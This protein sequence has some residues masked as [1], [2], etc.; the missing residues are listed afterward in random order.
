MLLKRRFLEG[1][2]DGS[3]SLVFRRWRKPTVKVGG[4]LKTA[5]GVLAIDDIIVVD[6]A[7]ITDADA[8]R[9]GY[10]SAAEL[11]VELA[12]RTG[13][14]IY[15]IRVRF[16][17]A[18]P[19]IALRAD[20]C[21]DDGAVHVLARLQRLDRASPWTRRTL[22]LVAR[23]PGRR[24]AELARMLDQEVA[25][26]KANVRKLKALGLTESLEIGYRLSPRGQAV[27]ARMDGTSD[28]QGRN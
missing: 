23:H 26:F 28:Q 11:K 27:L 22:D 4:S 6:E 3:I 7:A 12:A 18:D 17:G 2:A 5:V 16:A 14:A 25:P 19:R 21:L 24:A 10:A 13:G 9:A 20:T 1:I 8:A 15:R